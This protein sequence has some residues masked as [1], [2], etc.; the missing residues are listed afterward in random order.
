MGSRYYKQFCDEL[1]TGDS[2][3]VLNNIDD[4]EKW[5]VALCD[6]SMFPDADVSALLNDES[7]QEYP[8]IPLVFDKKENIVYI[9]ID[10]ARNLSGELK[11]KIDNAVLEA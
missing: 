4:F 9:S 1:T 11:A 7:P 6:L 3:V 8:C 5:Y 2:I 10:L